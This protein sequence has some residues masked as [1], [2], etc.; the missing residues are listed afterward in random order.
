AAAA[1]LVLLVL[2]FIPSFRAQQAR[3]MSTSVGLALEEPTRRIVERAIAIRTR[4]GVTGALLGLGG[5]LTAATV[6]PSD[7]YSHWVMLAGLF[8]GLGLGLAL[9]ALLA[10]P[11][12]SPTG[13]RV[14]RS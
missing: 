10:R 8:L 4:A 11:R 2:T 1:F 5:G 7:T 13:A 12:S 14:A 3:R 6:R 9:G